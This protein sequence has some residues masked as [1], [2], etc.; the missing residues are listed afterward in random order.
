V[1]S[2]PGI[3]GQTGIRDSRE[4]RAAGAAIAV[5]RL[6]FGG[7]GEFQA[8]LKR[9]VDEYFRRTGKRRRDS[10]QMYIK[11]ALIL[12]C[13]AASYALLTFVVATW[14]LA[15]PLAVLLGCSTAGIGFNI[16]HDAGHGA[17]SRHR[18]VNKI[19]AWSLD[20]IG[21]SSYFWRWKHGVYHHTY[22]N[23]THFDTDVEVAGVGRLTPHQPWHPAYR[24]QHWYIWP[25]YG[26]MAIKWHLYDDFRDTLQGRIG[27]HPVP[28]PRGWELLI[29]VAGKIVF[30]SLAFGIPMLLHRWWV[31]AIYYAMATTVLGIL[32]SIVFQ[33]AHCVEPAAF[34]APPEGAVRLDKEWAV[35]QVETTVDFARR[36]R[37]LSWMLGG[38]NFQV[39]HHLFP[40]VSHV[41][42]PALSQLVE[43]ACREFGLRY[44][45]HTTF[46]SG[47]VS[48]VRWLRKMG[49]PGTTA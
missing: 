11:A 22:S 44:N 13:F 26:L 23:I 7:S 43:N 46:W 45:E 36:N 47:V 21:G 48:H 14:W 16:M 3:S 2:K 20:L 9:R 25:L 29:F 30:F 40:R 34:P 8:E 37:I 24:W 38:L 15:V 6:T 12:S 17:F 33:L 27:I 18:A 35:H 5:R 4:G 10:P 32:L 19:M 41:H 49:M 28:R 39:E 42:Y 31:V 1:T